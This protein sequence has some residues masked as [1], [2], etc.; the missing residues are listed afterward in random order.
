MRGWANVLAILSA[1]FSIGAGCAG[2]GGT[3]VAS[4]PTQTIVTHGSPSPVASGS[5]TVPF[6]SA[7]SGF[8]VTF[9]SKHVPGARFMAFAPNGDL[10]VAETQPGNVVVIRPG[11]SPAAYPASFGSALALPHGAAFFAGKLYVATWSGVIRYNYPS[12]APTT[13]FSNM[14]EGGDHNQRSLAIAADG[15]IFVSS[16]SNC[17]VCGESNPRFATVLHYGVGDATGAIYARGLRNASGMAFDASGTLWAVV[18][19]RDTHRPH[20]GGDRQPAA[21]RTRPALIRGRFRLAAMLSESGCGESPSQPGVPIGELCGPSAGRARL[22]SA[23]RAAR[24]RVLQ[25]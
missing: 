19:Q 15:S 25:R 1:L 18:N 16:G 5:E 2:S 17:N 20:A 21:G 13:L 22:P 23:L 10:V 3:T 6:L 24:H 14:P 8:H 7:P 12:T 4:Q 9:V 11:S